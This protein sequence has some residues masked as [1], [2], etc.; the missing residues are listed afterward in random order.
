M[1]VLFRLAL[2]HNN[3]YSIH[4]LAI[5]PERERHRL[6]VFE[7]DV[8][9]ANRLRSAT[10]SILDHLHRS[11]VAHNAEELFEVLVFRLLAQLHREDGSRVAVFER[12]ARVDSF[13]RRDALLSRSFDFDFFFDLSRDFDLFFLNFLSFERDRLRSRDLDGFDV[14]DRFVERL[15][16]LFFCH[17]SVFSSGNASSI[18]SSFSFDLFRDF[19]SALDAK[20]HSSFFRRRRLLAR[21]SRELFLQ[22]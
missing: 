17:V 4:L 5:E 2:L 16:D 12:V 1:S 9:D 15:L 7:F 3:R 18:F 10:M 6:R 22:A 20:T 11:H 21:S 14:L 13:N 19:L 8:R